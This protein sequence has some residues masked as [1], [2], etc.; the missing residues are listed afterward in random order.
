MIL[1]KYQSYLYSIFLKNFFLI[2]FVFFCLVIVVN[3]F[4]EIRF[5]E[6][7]NIDIL[8]SVYLSLLNTPSLL[9]E[10][11]PFIFL[12]TVKTF[13]LSL[14]DTGI[15]THTPV[16]FPC[17]FAGIHRDCCTAFKAS[18]SNDSKTPFTI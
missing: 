18:L 12:I 2:S 6:K 16:R 3:F 7:N 8:Y 4:E 17:C 14:N 13:Y 5:A 15:L 1:K 10:I 9:F 11:F